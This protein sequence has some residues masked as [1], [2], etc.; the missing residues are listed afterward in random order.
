[1]GYFMGL[2]R[3]ECFLRYSSTADLH[4]VQVLL[5]NQ[6]LVL[7]RYQ[8]AGLLESIDEGWVHTRCLHVSNHHGLQMLQVRQVREE[9]FIWLRL[10]AMLVDEGLPKLL[11]DLV[12]F[13]GHGNGLA[14][15]S[16]LVLDPLE[17]LPV[18]AI[19]VLLSA[20]AWTRGVS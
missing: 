6:V 2:C 15:R 12:N 10:P 7:F 17:S 19:L 18:A 8:Q 5:W 11:K 16:I 20:P 14:N 1:M 9:Q 13:L 3:F 4:S